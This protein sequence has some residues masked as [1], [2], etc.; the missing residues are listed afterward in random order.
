MKNV[1]DVIKN[2]VVSGK[3]FIAGANLVALTAFFA[4]VN[5]SATNETDS[6]E[7]KER[8]SK[9]EKLGYICLDDN[10]KMCMVADCAKMNNFCI[11]P[12]E[13]VLKKNVDPFAS[14]DKAK[15]QKLVAIQ[16]NFNTKNR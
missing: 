10:C 6:E 7:I 13:D 2:F 3:K 16:R 15:E 12:C 8:Q 5:I 14:L 1:K 4:P 9:I 11:K